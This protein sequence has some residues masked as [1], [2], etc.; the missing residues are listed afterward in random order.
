MRAGI[1]SL[2]VDFPLVH[3]PAIG[4]HHGNVVVVPY[5]CNLVIAHLYQLTDSFSLVQDKVAFPGSFAVIVDISNSDFA[6]CCRSSVQKMLGKLLEC[7][8]VFDGVP[9]L[10]VILQDIVYKD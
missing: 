6:F 4:A 5:D 3:Q 2:S 8:L 1:S 9:I 7:R 10:N